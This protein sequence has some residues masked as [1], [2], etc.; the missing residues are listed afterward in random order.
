[1]SVNGLNK[2]LILLMAQKIIDERRSILQLGIVIVNA[3]ILIAVLYCASF[4][5]LFIML[6][7]NIF[8]PII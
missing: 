2:K 7:E 8:L 3:C 1:M 6:F 5:I 4:A